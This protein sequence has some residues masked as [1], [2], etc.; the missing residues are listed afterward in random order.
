MSDAM[1][2]KASPI[3]V[4]IVVGDGVPVLVGAHLTPRGAACPRCGHVSHRV[5]SLD[6]RSV[7]DLPW[8]SVPVRW[9]LRCRKFW[10]D[11][12]SCPQR[13]FGERWPATWLRPHQ[14]RTEAV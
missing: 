2:P 14:Q 7:Q 11:T 4:E 8:R 3:R 10:C 1:I 13:V 5:H 9:Q 6:W 12:P